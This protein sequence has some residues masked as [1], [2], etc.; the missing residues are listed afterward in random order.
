LKC[1]KHRVAGKSAV[2]VPEL[3]CLSP[4]LEAY[5][6]GLFHFF[7]WYGKNQN[8]YQFKKIDE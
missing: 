6:G 2:K 1:Q 4:I 5:T 3:G 7:M 8:S